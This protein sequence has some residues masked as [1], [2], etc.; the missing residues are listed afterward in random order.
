MIDPLEIIYHDEHMVAVNKPSGLMIHPSKMAGGESDFVVTRLK[1]QLSAKIYTVH[2]LDRKTSGILI[3]GL[4]KDFARRIQ[5]MFQKGQLHKKYLAIVR[6]HFPDLL[7]HS[8]DLVDDQGHL[9]DARTVFACIRRSVRDIPTTR[10]EQSRYSLIAARPITGRYHQIRRHLNK[11]N[12]PVIGDRKH[13]CSEQN[14]LM[15]KY[16]DY[17]SMLLHAQE[18]RFRHPILDEELH[19]TANLSESFLR[20]QGLLGLHEGDL[21]L[22]I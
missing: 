6:G 11:L 18:I 5:D 17:R 14:R 3:C 9:K 8:R 1:E 13:G 2:R 22:S 19:L 16:F 21:S 15:I 10:H 7:D 4:T 12:H 20:I